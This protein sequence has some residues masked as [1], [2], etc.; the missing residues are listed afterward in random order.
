MCTTLSTFSKGK[1]EAY[2][3]S[4]RVLEESTYEQYGKQ[5]EALF[6]GAVGSFS[7]RQVPLQ[8]RWCANSS[9]FPLACHAIGYHYESTFLVMK[10]GCGCSVSSPVMEIVSF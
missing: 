2:T 7:S 10:S 6:S 1:K 4:T 3:D 5:N 9:K 8:F